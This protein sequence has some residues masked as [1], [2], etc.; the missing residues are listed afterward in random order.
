MKKF[1]KIALISAGTFLSLP[2]ILIA[3]ATIVSTLIVLLSFGWGIISTVSAILLMLLLAPVIA[4]L[5][6]G[7]T[8]FVVIITVLVFIIA[9]FGLITNSNSIH[10]NSKNL[11]I[12]IPKIQYTNTD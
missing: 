3:L 4:F 11:T 12:N 1:N 9:G 5:V 8:Y 2:A 10:I 7:V 6:L